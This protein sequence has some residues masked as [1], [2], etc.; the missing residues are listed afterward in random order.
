MLPIII[1]I[2]ILITYI[3]LRYDNGSGITGGRVK[4]GNSSRPI[5][6]TIFPT[7]QFLCKLCTKNIDDA[8]RNLTRESLKCNH[9]E[10]ED[11]ADIYDYG[12]IFG[13][14]PHIL[15]RVLIS[16]GYVYKPSF[17]A[18]ELQESGFIKGKFDFVWGYRI[19]F[20]TILM[21]DYSFYK[22]GA[23]LKYTLSH[24]TNTLIGSRDFYKSLQGNLVLKNYIPYTISIEC[25]KPEFFPLIVKQEGSFHQNG[26]TIAIN[27]KEYDEVRRKITMDK[28][29]KDGSVA[30]KY[31]DDPLLIDG[32]KYHFR[33]YILISK[34]RRDKSPKFKIYDEWRI[35]TASTKYKSIADQAPGA[36]DVTGDI[37]G[38]DGSTVRY[39]LADLGLGERL[40]SMR[41]EVGKLLSECF[42][43]IAPHVAIYDD[44]EGGFMVYGCDIMFDSNYKPWLLEI[45]N[46]T[47]YSPLG[48]L[49]TWPEYRERYFSKYFE[50]LSETVDEFFGRSKK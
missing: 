31:I 40:P 2:L 50:W 18:D 22:A 42:A 47:G 41:L 44:N 32:K 39:E 48:D 34:F 43:E 17:S 29:I 15:K 28:K 46:S 11:N 36:V 10:H 14:N 6:F 9:D 13:L 49:K 5:T 3:W 20:D 24:E 37:S 27:Q 25:E 38:V 30:S 26:I 8:R 1:L 33:I 19:R 21:R 4:R 23:R 12:R 35:Y 16:K 7:D 45:N